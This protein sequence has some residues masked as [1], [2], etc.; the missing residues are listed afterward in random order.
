MRARSIPFG[1]MFAWIPSTFRL[2]MNHIGAMVIATLLTLL[3]TIACY[4]PLLGWMFKS[5]MADGMP[6]LITAQQGTTY[7]V[8]YGISML[9]SVVVMGPVMA[10]WM[11]MS[12]AA[13]RGEA[14]T[15]TQVFALFADS[16]RWIQLLILAVLV[17]AVGL[18][19]AGVLYLLFGDAFRA[20]IAMQE[21]QNAALLGGGKPPP[22]NMGAFG[23]IFLLYALA[24]PVFVLLQVSYFVGVAEI[25]LRQAPATGAFVDAVLGVLRNLVK[26]LI[27]G[28][29]LFIGFVIAFVLIVLVIGLVVAALSFINATLAVVAAGLFYIASLLFFYPLMFASNFYVWKD[30]LGDDEPA[31]AGAVAL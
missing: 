14:I 27:F 2:V 22:P 19:F 24:L 29:C 13:D 21:A 10:G 15:G 5:V 31:G 12:A 7:W 16:E 6:G 3:T 1:S 11:R 20:I 25:G 28:F 17:I 18:A 23:Q 9:L 8:M 26:L 30:M 4:L